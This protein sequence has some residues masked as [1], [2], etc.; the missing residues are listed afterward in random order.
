M[1]KDIRKNIDATIKLNESLEEGPVGYIGSKLAK[2]GGRV[3]AKFTTGATK[4]RLKKGIGVRSGAEQLIK[5]WNTEFGSSKM[6]RTPMNIIRYLAK[7]K[8]M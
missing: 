4:K 5:I 7:N 8:Q 1:T 6:K 2:A 3:G